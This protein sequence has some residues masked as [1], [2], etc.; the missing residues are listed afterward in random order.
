QV[1]AR[2]ARG[3]GFLGSALHGQAAAARNAGVGGVHIA[4]HFHDEVVQLLAIGNVRQHGLVL[5]LGRGPVDAVHVG[6]VEAVLHDAP[7]FLENLAVLGCDIDLHPD[8][9]GDSAGGGASGW[10]A[11]CGGGGGRG[12]TAAT[13]SATGGRGPCAG[14]GGAHGERVDAAAL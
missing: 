1:E 5:V 7:G 4:D 6:I 13:A 14:S 11:G 3:D 12:A 9:E 8:G 2:V 10:R